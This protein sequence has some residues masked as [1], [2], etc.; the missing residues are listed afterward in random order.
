[1]E[2]S[3]SRVTK[4]RRQAAMS[5]FERIYLTIAAIGLL[6]QLGN[7]Y[8]Q[9]HQSVKPVQSQSLAAPTSQEIM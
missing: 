2:L 9:F 8:I 3:A 1:M 4:L 5:R 6:I 7:L